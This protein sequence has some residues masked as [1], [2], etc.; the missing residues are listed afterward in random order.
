MD[1]DSLALD[2]H[3]L[4]PRLLRGVDRV[5]SKVE[6]AGLKLPA[7]LL[8]LVLSQPAGPDLPPAVV[9]ASLL[10][11]QP[12]LYRAQN[13]IASMPNDSMGVLIA[14]VRKLAELDVAAVA[15]DLS[16][17]ADTAPYG[18]LDWRP[19]SREELAELRAAAGVPFWLSGVS[20][21]DDADV[22][23]EAGLD[24]VIVHSAAGRLLGGPA[25]IEVLPEVVDAVAGTMEVL[26]GG[27]VRNGIDVFR[28]LAVGADAVVLEGDRQLSHLQ[29]ELHYAMRLT[30]CA[31]FADIGL[32]AIYAPL[33]GEA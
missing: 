28:L 16:N 29:A 15:L 3:R 25:V 13:V 7:P 20:S 32:D 2:S 14:T 23:L 33:F 27:L 12:H 21:A 30:G 24:A 5:D 9:P 6:L 19:R 10:L 31:G 8:P 11:A 1:R 22:A 17:M 4:L 18:E 26:A